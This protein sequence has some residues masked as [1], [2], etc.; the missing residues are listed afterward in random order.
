MEIGLMSIIVLNASPRKNANTAILCENVV[1]GVKSQNKEVEYYN[2]YDY[3]FKGC[4]SCFACHLKTKSEDPLCIIQDDIQPI[5]EK[6]VN[7]DAIVIAT[8][9]YYGSITSYAQAFLERLLFAA[10]TYYINEEGQ[11]V[12]K[13]KR[14][15]KTAMIYTMNVTEDMASFNGEDQLS[16]MRGYLSN[17][18]GE[19]KSLYVYDTKQFN[20]YSLY[21][22]NMFDAQHKIEQ[23]EKQFPL[24]CKKAYELGQE[25]A[26]D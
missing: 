5:L 13:I 26:S 4:V 19:C 17:I 11:R 25:L 23:E 12:S 21:L 15:I 3:M 7:A 24:D 9:I 22:N 16:I 2:L 10:D 1:E 18:F 20:D 6:C 8:P 14:N